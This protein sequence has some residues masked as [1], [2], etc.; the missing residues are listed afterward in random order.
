LFVT[1]ENLQEAIKGL[2]TW[3][4]QQNYKTVADFSN[5]FK[6]YTDPAVLFPGLYAER[7]K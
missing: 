1:E 5:T 2:M 3:K 4:G 6:Y 7:E